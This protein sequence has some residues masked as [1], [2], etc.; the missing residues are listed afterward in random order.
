MFMVMSTSLGFLFVGGGFFYAL[1]PCRR[2]GHV[3]KVEKAGVE[4]L[5]EV[6]VAVVTVDDAG[7]GLQGADDG[8]DAAGLLGGDF[9][10]FV[11]QNYVAELDLLD[12]EVFDV[13]F[14]DVLL[15]EGVAAAKLA[16]H[17]QGVDDGNDAVELGHAAAVVFG[18]ERGD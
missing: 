13:F 12:N 16:L 2:G 5:R 1:Y 7:F 14:V 15:C 4:Q 11:E 18:F 10:D 17:P 3:F 8:A 6:Y 9:R